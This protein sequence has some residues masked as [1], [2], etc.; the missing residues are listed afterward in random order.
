VSSVAHSDPIGDDSDT[1][2]QENTMTILPQNRR[3]R[4]AAAL[5]L[6]FSA[7]TLAPA[8][9]QAGHYSCSSYRAVTYRTVTVWEVQRRP[10]AVYRTKYDHC[11]RP[12]RVKDVV[13]QSVKVP[14]QR[15][16]RVRY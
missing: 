10:V 12:Y 16:V 11:R 14:V 1:T 7:V 9:S 5:L 6:T 13:Y 2:A 8:I 15:L 3:L 4:F